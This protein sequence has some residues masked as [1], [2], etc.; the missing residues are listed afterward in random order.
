[1]RILL[2][3]DER[4]LGELMMSHLKRQGFAVDHA[5]S[6]AEADAALATTRFDAAVFDLNL[7]DGDGVAFITGLRRGG[8]WLPI[9]AATARGAV[10]ER[11]RSLDL[12]VDDY[13]TKPFDLREMSARLRA[14]LRRPPQAIST[15]RVAGNVELDTVTRAVSV[16]GRPMVLNRRLLMLL[17]ALM[18][19][20][21]RVV[22]RS[23]IE[24]RIYGIDELVE[25][26]ALEAHV[27][28]LR[29]ALAEAEASLAIHTVRGV[30]YMLSEI[31]S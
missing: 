15:V 9:L 22:S 1:M 24:E 5:C 12:G 17:E 27:S 6:L 25:S 23:A 14:L 26:N 16:A 31:K 11:I 29:K 7:P 3:E 10:D 8:N 13:L 20:S 2:V 28:R 18:V 21:G 19:S 30:G 4:E